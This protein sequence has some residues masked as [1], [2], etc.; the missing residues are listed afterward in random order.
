MLGFIISMGINLAY[1]LIGGL[2]FDIGVANMVLFIIGVVVMSV[3]GNML[4]SGVARVITFCVG[5]ALLIIPSFVWNICLYDFDLKN[6]DAF[7]VSLFPVCVGL[8]FE[9]WLTC[10][11]YDNTS[12]IMDFVVYFAVIPISFVF[13][14][15]GGSIVGVTFPLLIGIIGLIVFGIF[16][17]VKGAALLD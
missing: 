3:A 2:V 1:I 16:R 4:E 14:G 11:E 5:V 12:G 10:G 17:L 6:L 13:A 8:S 9:M 7:Q 15:V